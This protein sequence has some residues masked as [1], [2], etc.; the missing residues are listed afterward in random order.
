MDNV[1][2]ILLFT[3]GI[4]FIIIGLA[5]NASKKQLEQLER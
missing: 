1:V 5:L 2:I 3:F 4:M